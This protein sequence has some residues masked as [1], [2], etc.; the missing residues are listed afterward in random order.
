MARQHP[1]RLR[2]TRYVAD[3]KQVV[4][5]KV[6]RE[7]LQGHVPDRENT[8]GGAI[9]GEGLLAGVV[10]GPSAPMTGN[11]IVTPLRRPRPHSGR[12]REMTRSD[13]PL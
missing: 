2:P 5:Y 10:I 7:G 11:T 4:V 9:H 6:Y 13:T 12:R 1:Q 3:K 8:S